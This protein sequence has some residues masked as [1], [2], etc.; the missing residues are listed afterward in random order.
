MSKDSTSSHFIV[1]PT[2]IFS[3]GSL[4]S[5][6][7]EFLNES[8]YAWLCL[9]AGAAND[10][11][12]TIRCGAEAGADAETFNVAAA[13]SSDFEPSGI[14]HA[15]TVYSPSLPATIAKSSVTLEDIFPLMN[16]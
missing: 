11:N 4:S 13:A 9:R 7:I 16:E 15:G 8:S 12:P 6:V 1:S 5:R 2:Y 3:R 10:G 14:F